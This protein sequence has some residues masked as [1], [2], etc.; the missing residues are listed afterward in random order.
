MLGFPTFSSVCVLGVGMSNAFK[1]Q[2]WD[3]AMGI[4]LLPI[5]KAICTW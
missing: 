3:G 5:P 2:W 4:V 1:S